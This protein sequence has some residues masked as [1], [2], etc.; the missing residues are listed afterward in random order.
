MPARALTYR[1]RAA[2]RANALS[3][4]IEA[5]AHAQRGLTIVRTDPT[6]EFAEPR[7]ALLL[8][9][10]KAI[11]AIRG[12]AAPELRDLYTEADEL[13]TRADLPGL[14]FRALGGLVSYYLTAAQADAS[15][16]TAR[17]LTNARRPAPKT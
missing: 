11:A 9:H 8:E 3:A 12:T 6:S 15:V 5:V 4:H 2:E 10:G 16:Q 1:L 17:T 7:I 13:A 14:R